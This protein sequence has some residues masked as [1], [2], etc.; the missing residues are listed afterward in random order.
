MEQ[1]DRWNE[2]TES[3]EKLLNL[4]PNEKKLQGHQM[5]YFFVIN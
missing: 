3:A 5:F 1:I 2:I 4:M